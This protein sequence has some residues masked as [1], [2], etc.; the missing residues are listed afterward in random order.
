MRTP[1]YSDEI[2][3][4][5]LEYV[6]S[7]AYS[8]T[9]EYFNISKSTIVR[10]TKQHNVIFKEDRNSRKT[11]KVSN[12]IYNIDSTYLETVMKE[13]TSFSNLLVRL[14]LDPRKH[15]RDHLKNRLNEL[16]LDISCFSANRKQKYTNASFPSLIDRL[17]VNSDLDRSSLR[18]YMLKNSKYVCEICGNNGVFLGN[19]LTLQ[20]DHINGI[21]NDNRIEN[22]RFLCPNCHSQQPTSFGKNKLT[23]KNDVVKFPRK[24]VIRTKKF[25]VTKEDLIALVEQFPFTEIA[26]KF[27]VSGNAIKKRCVSYGIDVGNRRGFWTKRNKL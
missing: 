11:K 9:A 10:W 23:K 16:N 18:S 24:K 7:H 26:K 2:I 19:P 22:L 27:G 21:N 4:K 20:V 6:Q 12:K 15:Y 14:G 3:F 17:C 25:E 1:P 13:S 8:E 5:A